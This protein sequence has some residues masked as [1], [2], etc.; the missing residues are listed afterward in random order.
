[1]IASAAVALR[2]A[3]ASDDLAFHDHIVAAAARA[4]VRMADSFRFGQRLLFVVFHGFPFELTEV[5]GRGNLFYS[6]A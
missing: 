5:T 4:H 3:C 2:P 6:Y 1:V